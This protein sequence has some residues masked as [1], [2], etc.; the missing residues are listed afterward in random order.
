[1]QQMVVWIHDHEEH[2]PGHWTISGY[3]NLVIQVQ[4]KAFDYPGTTRKLELLLRV[5][6]RS[7]NCFGCDR[8]TELALQVL[9]LKCGVKR[10][11]TK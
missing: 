3:F 10:E 5:Y 1:M 9:T 2:S 7:G 6:P 11:A 4:F 8:I